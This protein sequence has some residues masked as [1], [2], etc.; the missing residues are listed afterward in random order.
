MYVINIFGR[1]LSLGTFFVKIGTVITSYE[2]TK[3][4]AQLSGSF[5]ELRIKRSPKFQEDWKLCFRG[6]GT[7]QGRFN[8]LINNAHR[9]GTAFTKVFRVV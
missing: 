3:K 5:H 6:T 8:L 1:F 4:L 7:C 9:I 2:C